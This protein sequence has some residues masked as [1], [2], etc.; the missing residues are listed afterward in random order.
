MQCRS[1][2]STLVEVGLL[3]RDP[4]SREYRRAVSPPRVPAG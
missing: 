3:D 1:T 4:V 2:G